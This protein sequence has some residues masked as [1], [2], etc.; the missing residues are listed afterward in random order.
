MQ[1]NLKHVTTAALQQC[2]QN[3]IKAD[4]LQ[5]A[6][7]AC[8]LEAQGSWFAELQDAEQ[9]AKLLLVTDGPLTDGAAEIIIN[10]IVREASKP[11]D[12][13]A[14]ATACLQIALARAYKE[15]QNRVQAEQAASAAETAR[16]AA[17]VAY[18]KVRLQAA[19]L[20]EYQEVFESIT[21]Y[22]CAAAGVSAKTAADPAA[23][24]AVAA[25][26]ESVFPL[27]NVAHFL[28]LPASDRLQQMEALAG[29]TCGICLYNDTLAV[30]SMAATAEQAMQQY[31]TVGDGSTVSGC[32][33]GVGA[34]VFCCQ[35]VAAVNQLAA[36]LAGGISCCQ[37]LEAAL[38]STLIQI[39]VHVG[40]SPAAVPKEAVLPLFEAAGQ[41]HL[42]LAGE[43]QLLLFRTRLWEAV[44]AALRAAATAAPAVPNILEYKPRLGRHS[45]S[46]RSCLAAVS[47]T[48]SSLLS[49]EEMAGLPASMQY[50]PAAA[51]ATALLTGATVAVGDPGA[52]DGAVGRTDGDRGVAE[53]S[54]AGLALA[55][56]CPVSLANS[57]AATG[58]AS[59]SSM[60]VGQLA[61]PS[62]GYIRYQGNLY[63]FSSAAAL[64][65]FTT[66]PEVAFDGI[67]QLLRRLPLTAHILGLASSV[68]SKGKGCAVAM[69]GPVRLVV[70]LHRSPPGVIAGS[71]CVGGIVCTV[72]PLTEL[73]QAMAGPLRVDAGTQTP[74][75]LTERH[76]DVNYEWNEWALRRRIIALANLRNRSTHGSQTLLS[77]FRRDGDSQTWA[78]KAAGVQTQVNAA[79]SMPRKLRY[80]TGLRGAPKTTKM[81]VVSLELDLGPTRQQ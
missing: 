32:S 40:S 58:G 42:A 63:G 12:V 39:A 57:A 14:A 27:A 55:G 48:S 18:K 43:L 64:R 72:P 76:I 62:V 73:M 5:L 36:D 75:H 54:V 66:F 8:L 7:T 6:Y 29:I 26:L 4:A 52:G 67:R 2:R 71:V 78:L 50:V 69:A 68:L 24:A 45:S 81:K 47:S 65:S 11:A 59:S 1:D 13:V 10:R 25:A 31:N 61:Q 38:E 16:L 37:S 20:P 9:P 17:A 79:S 49:E 53:Q 34:A 80:V 70:L 30:E 60:W 77:H 28:T 22:V 23:R 21:S 33:G 46:S 44:T 56:F 15:Q 35:A 3:G 41:M 51:V 74:T 19:G